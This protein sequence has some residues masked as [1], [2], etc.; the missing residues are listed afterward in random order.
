MKNMKSKSI[1]FLFEESKNFNYNPS[2][3][4]INMSELFQDAFVIDLK[5]FQEDETLEENWDC[6]KDNIEPKE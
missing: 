4:D 5:D 3:D 2:T 1:R 6:C